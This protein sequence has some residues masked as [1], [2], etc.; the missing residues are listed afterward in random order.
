MSALIFLSLSA[1]C[2]IQ[3]PDPSMYGVWLSCLGGSTHTTLLNIVDSKDFCLTNPLPLTDCH[4]F[5]SHRRNVASLCIFY[6]YF[7]ANCFSEFANCMPI[8]NPR[9][10]R[11]RLSTSSHVYFLHFP[12]A[13]VNQC[14]HSFIPYTGKL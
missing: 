9:P 3:G 12:N 1:A 4:D 8:H 14:I 13:R 7:H 10:R 6:R 11:T 5:L 2:S